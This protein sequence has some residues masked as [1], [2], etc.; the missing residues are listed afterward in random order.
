M[1]RLIEHELGG[2]RILGYSVAGEET[3]I[4]APELN[5]CF[6][7][8][9]APAQILS[10]DNVLLSHGHMD[11][12]AGIA[13]YFSQR[14]FVGNESGRVLLP[15]ALADPIRELLRV[16]GRIEGHISPS[17]I[18]GLEPGG[19]FQLRRD[20]VAHAFAV[21]HGVPALGFCVVETRHKLKREFADRTGPELVAIKKQGVEIEY[22]LELPLVA[23]C[24]DTAEGAWVENEFVRQAKVLVLECTFFEADH[25]R[26]A[27]AGHHMH[28]RDVARI[29]PKL[30]NEHF[31]LTHV[32]RRTAVRQ[33][34]QMLTK[35][36]PAHVMARVTFLMEGRPYRSARRENAVP[37]DAPLH[38]ER[39]P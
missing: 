7:I 39:S 23:F 32:T 28:V 17:H 19:V 3:V 38:G 16:W 6:D 12:A 4:A 21:N 37:K 22:K 24:G 31:L 36:V 33:A 5:V 34:R 30:E 14:N 35:M 9:K 25:V 13:Y 11:H 29:L 18:D 1:G 10:V 8:G 26:R 2:I 20:L 27:R 15:I